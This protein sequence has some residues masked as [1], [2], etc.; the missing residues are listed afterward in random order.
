MSNDKARQG[1]SKEDTKHLLTVNAIDYHMPANKSVAVSRAYKK[2]YANQTTNAAQST[3]VLKSN[4]GTD[5]IG[6]QNCY[7][8]WDVKTDAAASFGNYGSSCNLIKSISASKHGT[9]I[10]TVNDVG[11]IRMYDDHY[12]KSQQWFKTVGSSMGYRERAA[13][14]ITNV[15]DDLS[16][17]DVK[18]RQYCIP[19]NLLLG[20]FDS[21]DL[22]PASLASGLEITIQ[23]QDPKIALFAA[24]E[25]TTYTISNAQI[26]FDCFTLVD[27]FQKKLNEMASQG[28]GLEYVFE[29]WESQ[30]T[31][32][33]GTDICTVDSNKAASRIQMAMAICRVPTV[34]ITADPFIAQD[35]KGVSVYWRLGSLYFPIRPIERMVEDY[36][37]M[38]YVYDKLRNPNMEGNVSLSDFKGALGAT[39]VTLERASLL[40][41]TGLATNGSR[42]LSLNW[43]FSDSSPKQINVFIKYV[44]VVHVFLN[45]ILIDE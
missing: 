43:R 10:E 31:N 12:S 29:T 22:M 1:L 23:L 14:P 33:P 41:F 17:P 4:T 39:A 19:M 42:T 38:N 36:Y 16:A 37:N 44:K 13:S 28:S 7:L 21:E 24:G 27:S 40:N 35:H 11:L 5:Y 20:V 25:A 30:S 45:N 3:I 15:T 18:L 34:A 8:V 26:Q 6:S 9:L 2:T 32:F